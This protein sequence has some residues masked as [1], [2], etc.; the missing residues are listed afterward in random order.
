[1]HTLEYKTLHKEI[2]TRS[3]VYKLHII[4]E[5]NRNNEWGASQDTVNSLLA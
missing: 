1:M 2:V 3:T 4:E 5:N